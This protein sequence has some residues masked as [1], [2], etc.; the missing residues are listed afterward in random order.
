MSDDF[1]PIGRDPVDPMAPMER[2]VGGQG[3]PNL[4]P[5]DLRPEQGAAPPYQKAPPPPLP[6]GFSQAFLRDLVRV[7]QLSV[8]ELLKQPYIRELMQSFIEETGRQ[9]FKPVHMP[10]WP[11]MPIAG[12]PAGGVSALTNAPTLAFTNL[13]TAVIPRGHFGFFAW[14]GQDT[15]NDTAGVGGLDW[16]SLAWSIATGPDTTALVNVLAYNNFTAQLGQI[17][18]PCRINVFAGPGVCVLRV[19][20]TSGADIPNVRGRLQGWI[21]PQAIRMA[22]IHVN[23]NVKG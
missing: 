1:R 19:F 22:S 4:S 15:Q 6:E 12:T 8:G 17:E 16:A 23:E 13:V 20:N 2:G 9:S 18:A 14:L 7:T 21:W 11:E 5:F 3:F 10:P